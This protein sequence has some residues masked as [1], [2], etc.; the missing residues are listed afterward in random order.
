MNLREKGGG[1][2]ATVNLM[3]MM[4]V[5]NIRVICSVS[6]AVKRI[7][8]SLNG[9]LKV[10]TDPRLLILFDH[11]CESSVVFNFMS[12]KMDFFNTQF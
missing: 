12:L 7:K 3:L 10:A 9:C 1:G 4:V 2:S 8:L 5:M 11:F 6:A